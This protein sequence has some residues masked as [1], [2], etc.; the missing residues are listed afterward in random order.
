MEG[1]EL[2]HEKVLALPISNISRE[3]FSSMAYNA[4]TFVSVSLGLLLAYSP[5]LSLP[6]HQGRKEECTGLLMACQKTG[7]QSAL[8]GPSYKELGQC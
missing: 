3:K 2:A 1:G 5:L 4:C 8:Q 6:P 7:H